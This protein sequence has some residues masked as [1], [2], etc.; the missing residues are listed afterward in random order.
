MP[1]I[2][3]RPSNNRTNAFIDIPFDD[4]LRRY[5]NS[6]LPELSVFLR[7]TTANAY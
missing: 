6:A 5:E 1:L 7:E 4:K 3:N 2:K